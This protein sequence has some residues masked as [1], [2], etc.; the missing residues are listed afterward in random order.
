ME[1][2][3]Y[4]HKKILKHSSNLIFVYTDGS[5]IDNHVGAVAVSSLTRLTKIVYI[6]N[7]ETLTVYV[8]ELQG[9]KLAL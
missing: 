1:M 8:A 3:R 7:R 6:G 2:A 4:Q 5:G 9:I